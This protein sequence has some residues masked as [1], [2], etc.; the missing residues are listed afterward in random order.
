MIKR[1]RTILEDILT[2]RKTILHYGDISAL[3]KTLKHTFPQFITK[4]VE[5]RIP[6]KIIGRKEEAHDE[7]LT[8]AKKQYR[9]FRFL[10]NCTFP[11]SVFIYDEKVAI[12]NL[13]KEPHT[14]IIIQNEDFFVTQ[15]NMFEVLWTSLQ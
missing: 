8:T 10:Q 7:L 3:Q 1:I 6:I 12:L 15:K 13:T 11:S 14:G 9:E 4:R 5:K 2:S